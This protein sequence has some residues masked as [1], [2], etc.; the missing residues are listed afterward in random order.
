MIILMELTGSLA[1]AIRDEKLN[2]NDIKKNIQIEP[3]KIIRK[4]QIIVGDKKA[5][6]DIWSYKVEMLSDINELNNLLN[7][8]IP[9]SNYIKKIQ[10]IYKD[11]VISCY[12][13]SD[14]GQIG[15]EITSEVIK[16]LNTLGLDIEFHI[17]SF[18]YVQ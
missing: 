9:Y 1:F 7:Q 15:F 8:L 18:G 4:G 2:F 6:L 12:L 3:T 14:M 13:R 16:K 17:L 10:K 11:V 5:P